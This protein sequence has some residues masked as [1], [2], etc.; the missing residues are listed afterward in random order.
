MH[1]IDPLTHVKLNFTANAVG[2]DTLSATGFE[3]LDP[4]YDVYLLDHY[5]KDSLMI[6]QYG[7][8]FFNITPADTNS[9]G[10]TR[11]EL[12]FHKKPS[13]ANYQ[14]LSFTGKK[15]DDGIQLTWKTQ[16]ETNF[17]G[18]TIQR[19]DGSQQFLALY[20]LQSDG[21]GNYTYTDQ[22][23]AKGINQYR[24]MQN[25][26][27]SRISY[28]PIISVDAQNVKVFDN[29]LMIYPNPVI[30]QLQVKVSDGA[31]SSSKVNLTIMSAS[32][33]FILSKEVDINAIDENV[34]LLQT[35]SYILQITDT[36]TKK[37]IG[38]KKFIK[39]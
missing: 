29:N 16:N 39:L 21:N 31:A 9:F 15:V 12:V 3:T 2:I 27:F 25:D 5:K 33:Q 22:A 30:G 13:L 35:G 18:F 17:T 7:K 34:G 1:S 4:R 23:P 6:S 19:A 14:L 8:Y 11:F 36:A 10:S 26:A 37:V 28:S 38:R 32:G 24:L 20:S